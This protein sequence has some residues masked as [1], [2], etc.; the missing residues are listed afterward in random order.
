VGLAAVAGAQGGNGF[1]LQV[2]A[3]ELLQLVLE[4]TDA[5]GDIALAGQRVALVQQCLPAGG[6]A[7]HRL[8]L[9]VIAGVGVEQ[10]QLAGPRQQ[11]LL[12]VLAVDLDQHRGQ[13]GQ[14]AQRG[15]APID[16]GARAAVGTDHAAQL[17][18]VLVVE[19]VVAQPLPGRGL[20]IQRELGGQFGAGGAVADHAAVGAQ[21]GQ[22]A[23]RVHHQRLAGAG[24]ARN[25]GHAR[26]ELQFG[27]ADNCKI[28]DREVSEHGLRG[29]EAAQS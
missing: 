20:F 11:R 23:Q 25:H 24:L 9:G 18:L 19:F 17:A 6:G 15:R 8:A 5:V 12:L 4:E 27:G 13:L 29:I 26:P 28:L 16:E 10:G 21:A 22:E 7:A 2:L 14:L 3:L 1:G